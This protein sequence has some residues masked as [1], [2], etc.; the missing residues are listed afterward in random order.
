MSTAE[1]GA[2][3]HELFSRKKKRKLTFSPSFRFE[4]DIVARLIFACLT[5]VSS[6]DS[7]TR[8]LA[9]YDPNFNRTSLSFI[10]FVCCT[11]LYIG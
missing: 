3:Q 10:P 5:L 7:E 11:A 1:D 8:A 6:I 4:E 9:K 2:H